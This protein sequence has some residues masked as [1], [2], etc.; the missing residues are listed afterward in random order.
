MSILNKKTTILFP[1]KLYQQLEKVAKKERTSVAHLI[2]EA[3]I[4]RYLLPSRKERLEAIE[5]IAAMQLPVSD[6]PQIERE[7]AEGR[8]GSCP[9]SA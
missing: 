3:A 1:P 8:S 5:A 6:W 7:I 9:P 4:Q 2:R